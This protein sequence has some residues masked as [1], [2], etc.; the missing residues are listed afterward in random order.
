MSLDAV[1]VMK[2]MDPI[3]WDLAMSEWLDQEVE[4][5]NFFLSK[6]LYFNKSEVL[7]LVE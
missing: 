3:S 7:A 2:E 4:D 6:D 5:G 1:S